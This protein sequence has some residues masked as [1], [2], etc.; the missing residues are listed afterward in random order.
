MDEKGKVRNEQNLWEIR[1]GGPKLGPINWQGGLST[2]KTQQHIELSII[3]VDALGI[4]AGPIKA[5]GPGLDYP[6]S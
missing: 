2:L 6:K 4:R 5:L 3:E 1:L